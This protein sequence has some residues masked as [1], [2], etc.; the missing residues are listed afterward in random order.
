MCMLVS[1]SEDNNKYVLETGL[2]IIIF[3]MLTQKQRQK[4]ETIAG[5]GEPVVVKLLRKT[6]I[7]KPMIVDR[8][9][10]KANLIT[11]GSVETDGE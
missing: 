7:K 4:E 3:L 5:R 6:T 9:F 1:L 11:E 10:G 2:E 8:A